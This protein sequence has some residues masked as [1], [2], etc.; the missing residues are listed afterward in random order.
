MNTSVAEADASESAC[1]VH[2]RPR[3]Q[4]LGVPDSPVNYRNGEWRLNRAIVFW[5]KSCLRERQ[6]GG[7]KVGRLLKQPLVFSMKTEGTHIFLISGLAKGI[8][9][10][11][12]AAQLMGRCRDQSPD[13][14]LCVC[15]R[16][17]TWD[18]LFVIGQWTWRL[19]PDSECTLSE[20]TRSP[21]TL[22]YL[23]AKPA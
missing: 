3:F 7:G 19:W 21:V 15:S 11:L 2:T 22:G 17:V 18:S 10:T 1:Q 5:I 13:L 9:N 23:Q 20:G 14:A 4:I 12:S 6:E 16:E 8:I